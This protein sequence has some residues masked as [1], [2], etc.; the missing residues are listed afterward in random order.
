MEFNAPSLPVP[1]SLAICAASLVFVLLQ[2]WRFR[3]IPTAFLFLSIWMRYSIAAFHELTYP[4]VGLG[5]SIAA[6][7]SVV[8]VAAGLAVVGIRLLVLRKLLPVYAIMLVILVSGAAN[9]QWIGAVNELL[10]WAYLIVVALTGWT[11]MSRHGADRIL[12]GLTAVFLGP[13]VSQWISVAMGLRLTNQDGTVCFVGGYQNQQT[14]SILLLTFLFATC[15]RRQTNIVSTL[16]RLAIAALGLALA[17]YR[18]SVLAA[19]LPV[20]TLLL[21]TFMARVIQRQRELVFVIVGT[22]TVFVLVGV[23]NLAQERFSDIGTAVD[24][25]A[26]LIQ[27]P[28]YF[29]TDERRLFSGRAYLWSQYVDAH[30]QGTV[31]ER[32]LGF[33]PEAWR[34]R[35][36]LYAHNSFVSDL[37]EL[38]YFGIAAFLWLLVANLLIAFKISDP[39]K[40]LIVA[41]HA[42]FFIL[43]LATMPLW[44]IEGEILY[45]LVLAQT[46][47]LAAVRSARDGET[48]VQS[49][50][51]DA[52]RGLP[53]TA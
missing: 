21:S 37:Y 2:V 20:A 19:V 9:N 40:I 17:N 39:R 18:T 48:V 22:V 3:D 14:F 33:G 47:Y 25:G 12:G 41:W 49:V 13:I 11:A 46:W 27:P 8:V 23:A 44:A 28:Q 7:S 16:S 53:K 42:S 15:F 30:L 5:L 43:N 10:K 29:T 36:T 45:A 35:F 34:G 51:I 4:P 32:V 6:I 31:I 26:A 24:K 1:V 52:A 50:P 38:G